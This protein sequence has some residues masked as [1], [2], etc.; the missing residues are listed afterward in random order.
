MHYR[1]VYRTTATGPLAIESLVNSSQHVYGR[2]DAPLDLNALLTEGR[3][4]MVLYPSDDA[5]P[6]SQPLVEEDPRPITLVVPDGSW[7]QARR[8][9]RRVPGLEHAERVTLPP[10]PPSRW[11]LRREYHITG[12]AT[13][14]AIARALGIIE[15]P[16]VQTQLEALFALM[17][18]TTLATRGRGLPESSAQTSI[19]DPNSVPDG[20][21]EPVGH[22]RQ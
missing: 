22:G 9:R 6:L 4:V 17:V 13:F 5:R 16:E 7:R 10:G 18:E 20:S 2:R 21:Q 3:R 12:L 14:E 1:E 19:N 15:S 11:G 8:V